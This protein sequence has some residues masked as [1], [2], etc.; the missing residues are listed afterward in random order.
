LCIKSLVIL[1]C[2]FYIFVDH[3]PTLPSY[4][5]GNDSRLSTVKVLLFVGTNFRGSC[6]MHWSMGSWIH[7][8]EHYK[9]QSMKKLYFVEFLFSW[10]KWTTKSTKI[11]TPRLIMISQYFKIGEKNKINNNM[12]SLKIPKE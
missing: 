10:F 3:L 11:R 2:D 12:K 1:G 9:Q 7:G 8:F 5:I 4:F 6:K